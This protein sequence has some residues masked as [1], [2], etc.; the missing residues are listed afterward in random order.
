MEEFVYAGKVGQLGMSNCYDLLYFDCL[1]KDAKI[2]PSFLQNRFINS[3]A[4]DK[5]LRVYCL[6]NKIHY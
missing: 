3:S 2:K 4:F 6:K 5:D 1:F